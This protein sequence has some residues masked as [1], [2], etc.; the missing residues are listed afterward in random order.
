MKTENPLISIIIP[1]YKVEK[2]LNRCVES[3]VN[4]TYKNLEIILVDD[5][6]PDNCPK[7]CDEWAAKDSRIKVIHK[8]NDG[9]ANARNSGIEIFTGDYVIFIDSDDFLELDM[10][11][12]LLNLSV[13]YDADISRCGFYFNYE[14]GSC[15]T[16]LKGEP[17]I[18]ILNRDERIIDLVTSGLGGTVWNKLYKADIIKANFYNKKDG[19]S[20]DILYNYRVYKQIDK[21]VFYDVPKYHYVIR[22]SSITNREFSHSSFDIIRAKRIV[23]NEQKNN[24]DVLPYAVRGYIMSA[25]IVLS[26]CI[27]NNMYEKEAQN[28]IDDILF[29]KKEIYSSNLY[30]KLDKIKTLLLDISPKLYRYVFKKKYK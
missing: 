24:P 22:D 28:L 30:S 2:F 4:Q 27:K 5:G 9:L 21:T 17:Q 12:F 20:E 19:C 11:E 29:Y 26:G 7:M 18:L 16:E 10:V 8:Q 14:N 6:S 25:F 1:V 3:V 23:I 15:E 13:K